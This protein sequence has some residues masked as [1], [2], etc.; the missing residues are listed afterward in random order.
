MAF[1]PCRRVGGFWG[2]LSTE[3]FPQDAQP[4]ADSALEACGCM[5]FAFSY[6]RP[7]VFDLVPDIAEHDAPDPVFVEVVNDA[8]RVLFLPVGIGL[9]PGVYIAHCLITE[10]K[11][12]REK[13]RHM[14]IGAHCPC[15]VLAGQ[16]ALH[17]RVVPVLDPRPFRERLVRKIGAVAGCEDIGVRGLQELVYVYAVIGLY[18]RASRQFYIWGYACA[19]DEYIGFEALLFGRRDHE[20]PAFSLNGCRGRVAEY[21]HA[22]FFKVFLYMQAERLW[23]NAAA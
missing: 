7:C 2:K 16:S 23:E 17:E 9:E 6:E 22:P 10:I 3:S 4:S 14:V 5:Y 1:L 18:A 20:L 12:V 15:H 8:F 13:V 11:E 19:Y 21:V